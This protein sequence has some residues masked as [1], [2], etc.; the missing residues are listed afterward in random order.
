MFAKTDL[1]SEML[2]FTPEFQLWLNSTWTMYI[3]AN[4]PTWTMLSIISEKKFLYKDYEVSVNSTPS[5]MFVN[6]KKHC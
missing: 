3:E 2:I 6:D 4:G 5:K 1:I